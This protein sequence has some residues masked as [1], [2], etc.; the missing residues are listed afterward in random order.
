MTW[1]AAKLVGALAI[2]TADNAQMREL[3]GFAR[4][5][6]AERGPAAI[7]PDSDLSPRE[8]DVAEHL[9]AGLTYRE[10]GAQLYIAPKT[11]E[12][13]VARIRRKGGAKS[14]AEMLRALRHDAAIG[15]P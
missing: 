6:E 9:L 5:L 14:R 3:L 8:R 2:R 13:H 1:E 15:R 4:S 12:H 10:I 7:Q 11:V